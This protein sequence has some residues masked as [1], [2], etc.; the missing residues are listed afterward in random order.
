MQHIK[1]QQLNIFSDS[2]SYFFH[3]KLQPQPDPAW[4]GEVHDVLESFCVLQAPF[5]EAVGDEERRQDGRDVA[6]D[7]EEHKTSCIF[8]W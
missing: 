8:Q 2:L 5:D 1:N 7:L 6:L 3:S 4:P